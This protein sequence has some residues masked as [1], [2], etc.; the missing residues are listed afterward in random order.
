MKLY[1]FSLDQRSEATWT[2]EHY[3]PVAES[4]RV[5]AWT[6]ID[7]GGEREDEGQGREWELWQG[8]GGSCD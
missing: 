5:S 2:S 6:S 8:E 1:L 4:E 3:D 7:L